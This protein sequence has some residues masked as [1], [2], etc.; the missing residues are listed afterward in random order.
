MRERPFL[1]G[2]V[3]QGQC[4]ARGLGAPEDLLEV[5]SA[6]VRGGAAVI[7]L[8]DEVGSGRETW[9]AARLLAPRLRALGARFIVNDRL[10][11]ALAVGA[12]GVHLGPEDLPVA[13]ARA[14]V[15]EGFLIGASAGSLE[16]ARRAVDEGADYLGVGAIFGGRESKPDASAPR[17]VEILRTLRSAVAVPLVAIG[18]LTVEN[19]G[20]AIE[21]GADGVAV[22]RGLLGGQ[23]PEERA[24][25]FLR[26][27]RQ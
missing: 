7:Q 23:G 9:A 15:P 24:Q 13:S 19:A 8:R 1:Y 18:G 17:G 14:V 4:Q 10:D 21:A 22:I 20:Q 12:D 6:M 27:L 11:I 3:D 26:A 2:I 16:A 5:A 25:A